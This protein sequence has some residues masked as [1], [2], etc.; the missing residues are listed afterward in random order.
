MDPAHSAIQ[1]DLNKLKPVANI[2]QNG[3]IS[4]TDE[5]V[6]PIKQKKKAVLQRALDDLMS[7]S[8]EDEAQ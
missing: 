7:D 6:D 1:P 3:G 8:S 2:P 5:P 4:I